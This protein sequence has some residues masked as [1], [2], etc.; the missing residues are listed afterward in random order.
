MKKLLHCL[1][2]GL[3]LALLTNAS[4]TEPE[5]PIPTGDHTLSCRING[6]LFLPQGNGG[7]WSTLPAGDGLNFNKYSNNLSYSVSA[8]NLKKYRVHFGIYKFKVG[9][10]TLTDS[11]GL[12]FPT[13]TGEINHAIVL[14]N[15]IKYLSKQGSGTV[16][17]IESSDANRRGTFEFT[18]YN[19]NNSNDVL[20]ITN[21][22]F[23]N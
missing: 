6:E 16:T 11:D 23:D 12:F 5:P 20:R 2:L 19:E 1:I 4:C 8:S 9:T 3:I 22:Q 18:V 15:G 10:F 7:G 13:G 14:K 21:G 17:F